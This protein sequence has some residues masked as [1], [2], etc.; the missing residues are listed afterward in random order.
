MTEIRR[1]QIEVSR[2]GGQQFGITDNPRSTIAHLRK[3]V[4]EL[5]DEPYDSD[6]YADCLTLLLHAAHIAGISVET[7]IDVSWE[8]L[9]INRH[10]DWGEPDADGVVEHV[11][12]DSGA[13]DD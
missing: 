9:D 2:W 4:G 5:L 7:I 13:G 10:R 1:L 8:K 12:N 3:E 6:E 11:R